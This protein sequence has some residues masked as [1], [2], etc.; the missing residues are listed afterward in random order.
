MSAVSISAFDSTDPGV[1]TALANLPPISRTVLTLYHIDPSLT[2]PVER[3]RLR[4]LVKLILARPDNDLI[5]KALHDLR[6]MWR[7]GFPVPA[8]D[9]DSRLLLDIIEAKRLVT[10][11]RN[12]LG[13]CWTNPDWERDHVNRVL[14]LCGYDGVGVGA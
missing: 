13:T 7:R 9:D 14:H 8:F 11:L 2:R 4:A 5:G 3:D 10:G 6:V 1:I 12:A